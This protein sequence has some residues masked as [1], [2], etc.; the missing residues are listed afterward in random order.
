MD[1]K[2]FYLNTPLKQYEYM[3]LKLAD[4][5]P[6]MAVQYSLQNKATEDGWVYAEIQKEMYGLP[7][8]GLLAQ[9]QWEKRLE[10]NGY[11]QSKDTPRLWTHDTRKIPFFLI[12]DNFGIKYIGRDNADHLKQVLK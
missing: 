1:L 6:D 12:I 8:T 3:R 9:E 2:K 5:P 7:Q 11:Q 10:H 4:I